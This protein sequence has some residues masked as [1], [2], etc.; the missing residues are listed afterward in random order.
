MGNSECRREGVPESGSPNPSKSR[1]FATAIG[2][3]PRG[4]PE[5]GALNTNGVRNSYRWTFKKHIRLHPGASLRNPFRQGV[6][7]R[8]RTIFRKG[9]SGIFRA[10]RDPEGVSGR[11]LRPA[12]TR[13]AHRRSVPL[14]RPE[15][16]PRPERR[17]RRGDERAPEPVALCVQ[18]GSVPQPGGLWRRRIR[19]L[20]LRVA[21][22]RHGAEER[23]RL[24]NFRGRGKIIWTVQRPRKTR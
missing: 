24:R 5:I 18:L 20:P 23:S 3:E 21:D 15:R 10:R 11:Q 12:R 13:R 1:S 14:H 22:P 17:V 7:L 6:S 16:R 2:R 4:A 9:R 19:A 8:L